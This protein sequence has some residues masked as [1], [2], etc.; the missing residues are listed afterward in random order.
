VPTKKQQRLRQ[1]QK[2][3]GI[4]Y[5]YVY[6]DADG[7]ELDAPPATDK[8]AKKATAAKAGGSGRAARSVA[9]PSWPRALKWSGGFTAV[10][11][12]LATTSSK[13]NLAAGV[14]VA[15]LY[16]I[17]LTP[18]FYWMHRFQYRAWQ[19]RQ[20]GPAPKPKR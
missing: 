7:N 6:V 18:G 16:G 19:R 15:L 17:A 1:K 10:M 4:S 14:L 9:P 13:G 5:E 3:H 8:P 11:I 20:S 2:R 12:V